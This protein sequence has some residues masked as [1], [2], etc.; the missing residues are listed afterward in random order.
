MHIQHK[1][2]ETVRPSVE[3]E[4][5]LSWRCARNKSRL[6]NAISEMFPIMIRF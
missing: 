6:G 1:G 2:P 4:Q 5:S 3:I